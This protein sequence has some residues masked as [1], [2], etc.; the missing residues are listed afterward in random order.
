[1]RALAI[2]LCDPDYSC[3]GPDHRIRYFAPGGARDAYLAENDCDWGSYVQPGVA[4]SPVTSNK[5]IAFSRDSVTEIEC[6][7]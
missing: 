2:S 6:G 1:M 5:V 4:R 3:Q 7:G